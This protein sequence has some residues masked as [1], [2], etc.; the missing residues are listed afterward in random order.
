MH[1]TSWLTS[2][3]I[4]F[5]TF[6]YNFNLIS[7]FCPLTGLRVWAPWIAEGVLLKRVLRKV[8]YSTWTCS[9]FVYWTCFTR[10]GSLEMCF[11]FFLLNR[12]AE[13]VPTGERVQPV[14]SV[15]HIENVLLVYDP[16]KSPIRLWT[17]DSAWPLEASYESWIAEEVLYKSSSEGGVLHVLD[18]RRV[19]PVLDCWKRLTDEV[20]YTSW[21]CL[22]RLTSESV[23]VKVSYIHLIVHRTAESVCPTQ[24]DCVFFLR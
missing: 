4:Y 14:D 11:F 13:S 18:R 7:N 24:S 22:T 3:C 1:R 19:L 15:S 12:T 20:F 10:L 5:R 21:T 6:D 9:T 16:W 2:S 23:L 8:Y 17:T